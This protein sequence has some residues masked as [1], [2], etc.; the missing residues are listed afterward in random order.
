VKPK[1]IPLKEWVAEEAIREGVTINAIHFRIKRG[2]Y[3]TLELRR[4]NPRVVYV[5]VNNHESR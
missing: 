5:K 2:H 1:E 3:K 4:V